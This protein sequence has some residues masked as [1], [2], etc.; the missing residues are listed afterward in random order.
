MLFTDHRSTLAALLLLA[1]PLAAADIARWE[2]ARPPRAQGLTL[3]P[4]ASAVVRIE[5]DGNSLVARLTPSQEYFSRSAYVFQVARPAPAGVW[6]VVEFLDRGYGLI[7]LS[8]GLPQLKQ[9]GISRVNSGRLRRAVYRYDT[10]AIK[11]SIRIEGLDYL[12]SIRLT[13]E[14][15]AIEQAPLVEPALKFDVP[16]QRVTTAAGDAISPDQVGEALA[17]LRNQ[18]PLV[19]ALGFNGVESYVRWGYVER[20]R[21]AY[22]WSYYDAL[23]KEIEKHGLRWFPML[24]AGSGYA[25][26]E[27]LK[28]SKDDFGFVCLEHGIEHDTQ[29][30]FYPFQAEYASR[31]IAEFGKHYGSNKT[32]LGIR[33]GPSGDYGE[34]QYPARGPG[35]KFRESHTHIGYWAGDARAQESFRVYLRGVYGDIGKLNRAWDGKYGS[36]DEIHTFLPDT[37]RTRRQRLDFATWYMG[38]MS[39]WCEKWAI[40]SRQALP[41]SVIHQSSGGWGPV[42]IGTDFSYQARS[43]SKVKGGIRLTNESDNFPDN[44]TITRMASSAARFYGAAL[45]YEPGGYGSKRGVVAR[46]FNAVTTNAEH[47]FYYQ[48]NISG[49]DQ[50]VDAWLRN[51]RLLDQRAKPIIDVATFYPDTAL[52]LDDEILRYRWGSPYFTMARALRSEMD[53]DYCSEQMIRDGALERFKVLVF[54]WGHITEQA[55]LERIDQWVQNGGTVIFDVMPRGYP[56]S[57]E[58]NSGIAQKWA[59]GGTGK[60][61]AIVYTGDAVPP[62]FYAEFVRLQVEKMPQVHAPVRAAMRMEKPAG[63]YWSV[64][65]NGK[66]MLLNFSNHAA[67]VRLAGGKALRIA[68]YEI[69]VE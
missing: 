26:P 40:W 64:L 15:P 23:V 13:D 3:T 29:S 2:A 42:Q 50:A 49:N 8:P 35:Y 51:G 1:S 18:L 34:A 62:E 28:G 16:S 66:L 59:S 44:F 36:F 60:G 25:L 17:G 6:L 63:V 52:K 11:D 46:L 45:G 68:P 69:A 22:D 37:A 31:F 20:T 54:L 4:E 53:Y 12:R 9:W 27:W 14:Q 57:V 56:T 55:V 30:I 5:E 67:A 47:L 19:R 65:E 61:R 24:L 38:A 41:T 39:E 10:A 7:S 33:L 43:M 21:G 48:S 32:L 58:N